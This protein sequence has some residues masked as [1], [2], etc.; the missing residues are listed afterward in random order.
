MII[1]VGKWVID[2]A[3]SICKKWIKYIPDFFVNINV[4]L[5]QSI[6][7]GFSTYILETL[8][9]YKLNSNNIILEL[10]ETCFAKDETSFIEVLKHLRENKIRIAIDDFG[11][12]YSSLGRLQRI[13]I[14]IVK[15]DKSFVKSMKNKDYNYN[16]IKTIIDLCHS[17]SLKVCIEGIETRDELEIVNNFYA[18]KFQGYYASKPIPEDE[19]FDKHI[20]IKDPFKSLKLEKNYLSTNNNVLIDSD[21]LLLMMDSTPLCLNLWNENFENISC[22]QEAVNLFE[23]RD[24]LSYLQN[25]SLVE[26]YLEN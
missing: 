17:A 12:G 21:L 10:T 25:I 24:N 13:P 3:L 23:L 4:S 2:K 1:E 9:K 15:I 26:D 14:D 22:N 20:K 5:K 16:F 19:F 6:D 11:T 8:D 7:Y 18:D